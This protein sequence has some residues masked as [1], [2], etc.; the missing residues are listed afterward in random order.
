METGWFLFF[1]VFF[2]LLRLSSSFF[3]FLPHSLPLSGFP[4]QPSLRDLWGQAVPAPIGAGTDGSR[5]TAR[6]LLHTSQ[7]PCCCDWP[8][9]HSRAPAEVESGTHGR[10]LGFWMVF[11]GRFRVGGSVRRGRRTL[12]ARAR[13]L[14]IWTSES[15]PSLRDWK[16]ADTFPGVETPG[17]SRKSLR[18]CPARVGWVH[19]SS[20]FRVFGLSVAEEVGQKLSKLRK[21]FEGGMSDVEC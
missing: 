4:F 14:P 17:Y 21:G 13:V 18:D 20:Y 19:L 3:E 7:F 2:E 8:R 6:N 15:Q 16:P 9:R 11:R 1:H 10:G 12:H 5:T